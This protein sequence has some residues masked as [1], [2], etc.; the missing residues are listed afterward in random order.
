MH[1]VRQLFFAF[2]Y[3]SCEGRSNENKKG[4]VRHYIR[5]TLNFEEYFFEFLLEV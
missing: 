2:L 4:L 1:H 5:T 3:D